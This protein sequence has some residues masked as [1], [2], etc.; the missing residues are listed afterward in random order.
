VAIEYKLSRVIAKKAEIQSI[1]NVHIEKD[2]YKK[3]QK[4]LED[5][6]AVIEIK[7]RLEAEISKL[8]IF[9]KKNGELLK[10]Q[11][12]LKST[13]KAICSIHQEFKDEANK[14]STS[15]KF[16]ES[17]L[18]VTMF[19]IFHNTR[20]ENVLAEQL[21]QRSNEQKRVVTN[22]S[23]QY[24]EQPIETVKN[25]LALATSSQLQ[26]KG[27][28]TAQSVA[29]QVLSS[30]TY[31][32]SYELTYQEDNFHQM[33]QGKQAF[34]ILKLLLEFSEKTC[35]I[36]ID[37]PEDSL[38][39]RAIYNELVEYLKNKKRDRQI[40]LVTHNSNVVVSADAEQIIVANQNGIKL[41]NG[42][43]IKFQYVTGSIEHS[44]IKNDSE[45]S[46]LLSQGIR[47]HICEVLE[48]GN[49]AFK[50]REQKYQLSD[51]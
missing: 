40:I 38:D 20:V 37:Q 4:Q 12:E 15:L 2:I 9:D 24:A 47:E 11:T 41:P 48:G 34:V 42:N 33:S 46:V 45:K 29:T 16:K 23:E 8:D 18:Q 51:R 5:N 26:C 25:F 17:D 19:S 13:V 6:Q 27:S 22:F 32:Q 28:H 35:P 39:N 44:K 3:G 43:N 10:K 14:L 31:I 21:L 50:K 36:L 1:K 49:E 30:N 7:K